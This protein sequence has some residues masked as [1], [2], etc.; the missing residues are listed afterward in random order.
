MT[1]VPE[2]FWLAANH[3]TVAVLKF[4]G[5]KRSL[6]LE[7]DAVGDELVLPQATTATA[8]TPTKLIRFARPRGDLPAPR[9]N[10]LP[11]V[12][13]TSLWP[14]LL[15]SHVRARGPHGGWH[16][17]IIFVPHEELPPPQG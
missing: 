15:G 10:A 2:A 16:E 8:A 17:R 3:E 1:G 12:I 4:V 11:T 14:L 13:E 5:L 9:A 7:P 6:P